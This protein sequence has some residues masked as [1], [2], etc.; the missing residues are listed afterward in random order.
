VLAQRLWRPTSLYALAA[1][2][3]SRYYPGI[4]LAP[5]IPY[6]IH[7]LFHHTFHGN[8]PQA[9]QAYAALSLPQ[10]LSLLKSTFKQLLEEMHRKEMLKLPLVLQ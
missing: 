2:W 7:S 4:S 5:N 8:L 10:E 6:E 9:V 1:A 3:L